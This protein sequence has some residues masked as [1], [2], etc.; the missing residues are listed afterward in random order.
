MT[1][2]YSSDAEVTIEAITDVDGKN[3]D[4]FTPSGIGSWTVEASW[5][6][7]VGHSASESGTVE[8]TVFEAVAED[9]E[10][11]SGGFPGFP[12]GSITLGLAASLGLLYKMKRDPGTL[13]EG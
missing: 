11:P 6:G 8:F 2:T 9:E 3:S 5:L 12:V 7:D 13:Q 4:V 1:L 10:A